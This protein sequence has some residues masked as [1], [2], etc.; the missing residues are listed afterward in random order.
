MPVAAI[1]G[2]FKRQVLDPLHH[3]GR[4]RLRM[5]PVDRRQVPQP[6]EALCLKPT[7][8]FIEARPVHAP[9]TA[10]LGHIAELT[11]QFQ[12]TQPLPRHLAGGIPRR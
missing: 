11:S 9:L 10:R 2:V 7:F 4:R 1:G 8:P 3:L 6:V 12:H 5:A